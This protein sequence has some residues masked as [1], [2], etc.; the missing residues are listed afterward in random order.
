MI[1]AVE[2][3]Y[4]PHGIDNSSVLVLQGEQYAGKTAWVKSLLGDN[5]GD[6][7]REGVTLN[8][9]DKD[10]VFGV[11]QYWL[12]EL[13]ELDATFRK[14]D[15]A[16]LK[17]FITKSRDELRKPYDKGI[18]R[19]PRRTV[20][21][22]S[23]NPTHF[24]HD[25]TG[26]RRFWTV[27]CTYNLNPNHG[28]DMQQAWAQVRQMHKEG[29]TWKLTRDELEQLNSH[30]EKYKSPD[31]IEELILHSF[32][33]SETLPR[34]VRLSASRVLQAIG[35]KNIQS[36]DTRAAAQILRKHFGEPVGKTAGCDTYALPLQ[37]E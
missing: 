23:V 10:S 12:V 31:P 3:A 7:S 25:E 35:Y 22:A 29:Q 37:K 15:V 4:S 16:A 8:P 24:L 6:L 30:N 28:I 19:F 13:G 5:G 27:E 33:P 26:N 1:G 2:A 17:A 34:T 9:A 11:I 18:S 21:M 36:K 20:F 14:A 32:D